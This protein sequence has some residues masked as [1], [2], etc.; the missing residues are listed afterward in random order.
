LKVSDISEVPAAS[1]FSM[2]DDGGSR[3]LQNIVTFL[4]CTP[5][6]KAGV[7]FE[8]L[9]SIYQVTWCHIPEIYFV[10]FY[11]MNMNESGLLWLK[12]GICYGY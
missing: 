10:E 9:V 11:Q 3:F 7:S 1:T 5:K 6:M 12:F 4:Q 8:M 2:L